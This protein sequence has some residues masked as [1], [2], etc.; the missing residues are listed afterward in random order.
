MTPDDAA[1][2]AR[3]CHWVVRCWMSIFGD[4]RA[5]RI[6]FH[7]GGPPQ[8][9]VWMFVILL[10]F[11]VSLFLVNFWS[12]WGRS[13]LH[14]ATPKAGCQRSNVWIWRARFGLACYLKI[15]IENSLGMALSKAKSGSA[16]QSHFWQCQ[17]HSRSASNDASGSKLDFVWAASFQRNCA[18]SDRF[19]MS[20]VEWHHR[21]IIP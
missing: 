16:W 19:E 1:R 14:V 4:G 21:L 20:I 15:D 17:P 10:P 13:E 3:W 12:S 6:W 9:S 5:Y 18:S 11:V 7:K 2:Y 8:L